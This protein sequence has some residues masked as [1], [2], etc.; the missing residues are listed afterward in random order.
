MIGDGNK[1]SRTSIDARFTLDFWEK[2]E[3]NRY[4]HTV[5][6]LI[7]VYIIATLIMTTGCF[8]KLHA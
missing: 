2:K 4:I 8:V 6:Q 1:K 7:D 5:K 3:T